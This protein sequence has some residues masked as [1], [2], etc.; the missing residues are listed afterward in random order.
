LTDS[1]QKT[2]GQMHP[3]YR[4]VDQGGVEMGI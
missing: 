3:D 1:K 2:T 4:R